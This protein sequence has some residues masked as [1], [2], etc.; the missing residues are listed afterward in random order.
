MGGG[1]C[2]ETKAAVDAHMRFW[3]CFSEAEMKF[4]KE[5]VQAV[6][7][8]EGSKEKKRGNKIIIPFKD[9]IADQEATVKKIYERMGEK[10]EGDFEKALAADTERHKSYK[11]KRDYK[12]DTLE[13]L[14]TSGKAVEDRMAGYIKLFNL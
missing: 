6:E 14:G 7:A 9:Y 5:E 12:N 10:V 8:K 11:E 4:F 3:D 13:E 2:L 1:W